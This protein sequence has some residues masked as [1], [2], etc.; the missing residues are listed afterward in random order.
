MKQI[1][2]DQERKIGTVSMLFSGDCFK[3]IML[4][5]E[6]GVVIAEAT[7]NTI[8]TWTHIRIPQGHEVIGFEAQASECYIKSLTFLTWKPH[9]GWIVGKNKVIRK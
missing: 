8:G 4:T 1:K 9:A 5:D 3:G 2:V 6:E 7:W